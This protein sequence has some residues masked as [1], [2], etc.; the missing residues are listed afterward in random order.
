MDFYFNDAILSLL[1]LQRLWFV[2]G[3]S[4]SRKRLRKKTQNLLEEMCLRVGFWGEEYSGFF[5]FKLKID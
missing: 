5:I 2:A 3:A 4:L 1:Y